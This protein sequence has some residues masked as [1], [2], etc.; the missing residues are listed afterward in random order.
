VT[1]FCRPEGPVVFL[2][3]ASLDREDLD[4]SSL[5]RVGPLELFAQTTAEELTERGLDAWCVIVNKVVLDRAFFAA[6]PSLRLVCVVATGTNNVDLAAAAEHGVAV[7]NCQGY[8]TDTLAQHALMFILAL[9]RS[10]P[11]YQAAVAAGDWSRSSLFC[12]LDYPIRDINEMTLGIVGYGAI[13][14]RVAELARAVGMTVVVSERPGQQPRAG[15]VAFDEMLAQCDVVSLHC[16]LTSE[17]EKLINTNTLQQMRPGSLLINTARGGLVDEAALVQALR[18]GQLAGAAVDVLSE[19]P[20]PADNAL[21]AA[22]LP[23][24]IIT[25]HCAWGSRETRQ[26]IVEQTAENITAS[27]QGQSLRRVV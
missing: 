19:E 20:P 4:L 5:E 3:L 6:R 8:G 26:R 10:L 18:E 9:S 17:T 16:P 22:Q 25:P 7:A 21:L 24:V 11:Q 1:A 13:G 14:R 12:L 23:N 15:R 2:D 27:L